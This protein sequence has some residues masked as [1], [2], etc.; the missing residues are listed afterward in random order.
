MLQTRK[1]DGAGREAAEA[2]PVVPWLL[3]WCLFLSLPQQQDE[4]TLHVD[5]KWTPVE[6][7]GNMKRAKSLKKKDKV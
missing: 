1:G 5:E 7:G 4:E 3:M 6:R 2:H